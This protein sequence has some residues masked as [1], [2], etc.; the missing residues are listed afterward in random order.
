MSTRYHAVP[1]D[2]HA[3]IEYLDADLAI[4][5]VTALPQLIFERRAVHGLQIAVPKRIV[6][7]VERSNHRTSQLLIEEF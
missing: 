4:D 6:D 1:R 5:R 2:R 3:V 7:G